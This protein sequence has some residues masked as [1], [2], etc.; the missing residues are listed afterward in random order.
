M[1]LWGNIEPCQKG[2]LC[3]CAPCGSGVLREHREECEHGIANPTGRGAT[4]C[5]YVTHKLKRAHESEDS[6]K[7]NG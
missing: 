2:K 5:V 1:M 7:P 3:M 6:P 4:A